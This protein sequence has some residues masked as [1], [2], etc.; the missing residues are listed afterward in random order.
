MFV[1]P[2]DLY[3]Y[4]LT[5]CLIYVRGETG[6]NQHHISCQA[7]VVTLQPKHIYS[8]IDRKKYYFLYS[9]MFLKNIF[10]LKTKLNFLNL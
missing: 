8:C 1:I 7:V 3:V 9:N 4:P 10:T 2:F 6:K 5:P